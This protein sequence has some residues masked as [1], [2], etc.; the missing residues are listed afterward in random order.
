[1]RTRGWAGLV[2]VSILLHVVVFWPLPAPPNGARVSPLIL[3]LPEAH[4]SS[5]APQAE[6]VVTEGSDPVLKAPGHAETKTAKAHLKRVPEKLAGANPK[7]SPTL[8]AAEKAITGESDASPLEKSSGLISGASDEDL[9]PSL[10]R[11]RLAI[12]SEAIRMRASVEGLVASDF[13]GKL[14][15]LVQLRGLG[16]APQVS[17]EEAA[18]SEPVDRE[19]LAVFRRAANLVPVSI[20]GDVGEVSVRLPVRF[21][22]VASE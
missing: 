1:M 5:V 15:V 20:A 22:P 17:L 13:Q 7:K 12:A 10:S 14:V 19:V 2:A 16:S 4:Q 18:G 3:S 9:S 11:Y 6:S 21:G 8:E